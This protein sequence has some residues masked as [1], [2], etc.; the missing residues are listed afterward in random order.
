M[1][2]YVPPAKGRWPDEEDAMNAATVDPRRSNA[3]DRSLIRPLVCALAAL[4]LLAWVGVWADASSD[5]RD[6]G[7]RFSAWTEPVNL[8]PIVNSSAT[9]AGTFITKDGLTLYFSSSRPGGFGGLDI[10]V[11]QRASVDDAWETPQNLGPDINTSGSD[12]TPTVSV[13]GHRLYFASDRPGGFGGL[14][15]YVSRRH[16]KRDDFG[17]EPPVNLGSGVNTSAVERGPALLYVPRHRGERDDFGGQPPVKMGNGVNT[18]HMEGGPARFEDDVMGVLTLYFSS[19]R[20]GGMGLEDIY[21]STLQPD[22]T[23]GPAVIVPELSSAFSDS[24]PA[25]RRDG[26]EMFLC[27]TRTGQ[28]GG[29]DIWVSTRPST[30]DPWSSPVNLGEVVNSTVLDFRPAISFDGTALYFHSAR[31]GGF[32][33]YDVYVTTRTRIRGRHGNAR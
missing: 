20:P 9:E 6:D 33:E 21:A 27:S 1:Q 12:T 24:V 25:I 5:R 31:S 11:S 2:G 4:T 7:P 32:G 30:S 15:L 8:G 17:W 13:D 28:L 18:S 29:S 16:D 19:T 22:E 26:L 10:W 14:D 23:Y 3:V